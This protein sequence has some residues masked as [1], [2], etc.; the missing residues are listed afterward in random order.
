MSP[1]KPQGL[2]PTPK[3][4]AGLRPATPAPAPELPMEVEEAVEEAPAPPPKPRLG[5]DAKTKITTTL[6]GPAVATVDEI[7][8]REMTA[9]PMAPMKCEAQFLK[10]NMIEMQKTLTSLL[11]AV[12]AL[13][14][15]I[16]KLSDKMVAVPIK[17]MPDAAT[18][19]KVRKELS[20]IEESIPLAD[21]NIKAYIKEVRAVFPAFSKE[22]LVTIA[23]SMGQ[24]DPESETIIPAP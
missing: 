4:N 3:L 14:G 20:A 22:M 16:L 17:D 9:A 19:E 2:K 24:Y 11:D 18:T 13:S 1:L 12:N 5:K 23:A 8:E 21:D 7:K 10:E 15:D 6:K